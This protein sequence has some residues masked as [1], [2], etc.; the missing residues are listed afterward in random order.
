MSRL[1][2][3]Q[4]YKSLCTVTRCYS[5]IKQWVSAVIIKNPISLAFQDPRLET[6]AQHFYLVQS[7]PQ[8]PWS[9]QG[10][11]VGVA[12]YARGER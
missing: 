2:P 10:S 4:V 5:H 1:F 11:Q 7:K 6:C 9:T 3:V 12:R 8:Q